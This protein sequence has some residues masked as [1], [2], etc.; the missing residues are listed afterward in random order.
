MNNQIYI[1]STRDLRK[2]LKQHNS[3]QEMSTK[4]YLPW[5]LS[6]YEAFT[7][8]KMA[9]IREQKLKHNGNAIRELKKR[10]GVVNWIKSGAG[11]TLIELVVAFS[12]IAVLSTIGVA[13]FL[14]YSRSQT[15][16]QATNDLITTINA[17]KSKAIAQIKPN[18]ARCL[19]DKVLSGYKVVLNTGQYTLYAVCGGFNVPIPPATDATPI[20]TK[21]PKGVSF[22]SSMTLPM[23]ITFGVL[24]GGV[25]GSGSII[26]D[27][28]GV[29]TGKTITITPG[30]LIK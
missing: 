21:L 18:D 20:T 7:E 3:G 23:T 2:R 19:P 22:D 15:L 26:L 13:A 12:I 8:E 27:G 9:R 11:F 17:A 25:V 5:E 24:T 14:D 1:G 16:Q 28:I 29:T 6:Y 30:G 10:I 4:R